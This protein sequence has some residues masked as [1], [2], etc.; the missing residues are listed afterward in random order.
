MEYI[1][2]E[3]R[4]ELVQCAAAQQLETLGLSVPRGDPCPEVTDLVP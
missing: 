4:V 2:R 3:E 1:W